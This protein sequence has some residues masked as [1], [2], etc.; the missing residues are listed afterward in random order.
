MVAQYLPY[1]RKKGTLPDSPAAEMPAATFLVAAYRFFSAPQGRWPVAR[2]PRAGLRE[3]AW[4]RANRARVA[5]DTEP[6]V[7]ISDN[8]VAARAASYLELSAKMRQAQLRDALVAC[9]RLQTH[10]PYRIA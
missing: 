10:R 6:W 1:E 2:N 8:R 7:A 5:D 9:V 3:S 4:L